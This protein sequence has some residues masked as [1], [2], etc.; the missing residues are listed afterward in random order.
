MASAWLI[1]R[2]IDPQASFKFVA[3]RGYRPKAGELRFDM[4]EAEYTHEGERCTFQ[5]LVRRFA[6]SDAALA[7]I[8]EVV[9]DIDNKA[10]RY[11]RPETAG[12]ATV[13]RGIVQLHDADEV[14]LERG[15]EVFDQLYAALRGA[16]R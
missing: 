1:R 12:I 4:Y 10:E 8:G 7:A 13:V 6:L 15:N 3:A 5:T 16:G 11:S 14:R 9:A 2:F